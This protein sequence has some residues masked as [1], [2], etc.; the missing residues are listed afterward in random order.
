M[1]QKDHG[2]DSHQYV[3]FVE[4][5]ALLSTHLHQ[6]LERI[7]LLAPLSTPIPL[8][9][10]MRVYDP[11]DGQPQGVRFGWLQLPSDKAQ[12]E[13]GYFFVGEPHRLSEVQKEDLRELEKM[14]LRVMGEQSGKRLVFDLTHLGNLK[15]MP[16]LTADNVWMAWRN[17]DFDFSTWAERFNTCEQPEQPVSAADFVDEQG[18]SYWFHRIAL[19][20]ALGN[21]H[22]ANAE[23]EE[24]A[25]QGKCALA[26][27]QI[28]STQ[29]FDSVRAWLPA[30]KASAKAK[31]RFDAQLR[32]D[33]PF[34]V[35]L[36]S[37]VQVSE[38]GFT[39][40]GLWDPLKFEDS[41]RAGLFEYAQTIPDDVNIMQDDYQARAVG[42]AH[43]QAQL[44]RQMNQMLGWDEEN[45]AS[46]ESGESD[47]PNERDTYGEAAVSTTHTT[48]AASASE[49]LAR[50]RIFTSSLSEEDEP[51]H[52]VSPNYVGGEPTLFNYEDMEDEDTSFPTPQA[53]QADQ[54]GFTGNTNGDAN[55]ASSDNAASN[56][57][58]TDSSTN[59][60]HAN[61]AASSDDA[62]SGNATSDGLNNADGP[63]T[64][65]SADNANSSSNTAS[66]H[67]ADSANEEDPWE[68]ELRR[69][70][71]FATIDFFSEEKDNAV[72]SNNTDLPEDWWDHNA[73]PEEK[74]EQDLSTYSSDDSAYEDADFSARNFYA[75]DDS[76]TPSD[77]DEDDFDDDDDDSFVPRSWVS[78]L[79]SSEDE[80]VTLW[81]RKLQ[82]SVRKT[83]R[84]QEGKH[85]LTERAGILAH[86]SI[87]LGRE[88]VELGQWFR[89]A[90][91]FSISGLRMHLPVEMQTN[92]DYRDA[93]AISL[94]YMAILPLQALRASGADTGVGTI[95][96][97]G[98]GGRYIFA[99]LRTLT[100]VRAMSKVYHQITGL[101]KTGL[102]ITSSEWYFVNLV[103]HC[104]RELDTLFKDGVED[105]VE[106]TWPGNGMFGVKFTEQTYDPTAHQAIAT[107]DAAINE[108]ASTWVMASRA[109][110][111]LL[112]IPSDLR[113]S[114]AEFSSLVETVLNDPSLC[115]YSHALSSIHDA[116]Q[117]VKKEL[118]DQDDSWV[119]GVW[120]AKDGDGKEDTL[121]LPVDHPELLDPNWLHV[122]NYPYIGRRTAQIWEK[123]VPLI[124]TQMAEAVEREQSEWAFRMSLSTLMAEMDAPIDLAPLFHVHV[125]QGRMVIVLHM[126]NPDRWPDFRF[127]V[128][129]EDGT[130][131]MESLSGKERTLAALDYTLKVGGMIAAVAFGITSSLTEVTVNVQGFF[132]MS[133]TF[134]HSPLFSSMLQ[135]N[136]SHPGPMGLQMM[137]IPTEVPDSLVKQVDDQKKWTTDDIISAAEK[138]L[139]NNEE[140]QAAANMSEEELA[141]LM[142]HAGSDSVE[143]SDSADNADSM[144][145]EPHGSNPTGAQSD[146]ATH[147]T[148]EDGKHLRVLSAEEQTGIDL[149][150]LTMVSD[151]LKRDEALEIINTVGLK[152]PRNNL[153]AH[154]LYSMLDNGNLQAI[155]P[156]ERSTSMSFRPS[157]A[158]ELP[159]TSRRELSPQMAK[160]L[161]AQS[162]SDLAIE[163]DKMYE[164][165]A[166]QI[167]TICDQAASRMMSARDASKEV[168]RYLE[169]FPDPELLEQKNDIFQAIFDGKSYKVSDTISHE[170]ATFYQQLSL[171]AANNVINSQDEAVVEYRR[172]FL[173]AV[174]R[175][176]YLWDRNP[177][178]K[179]RYF[180]D[181][182]QRLRYNQVHMVP[183]HEQQEKLN[184]KR[185]AHHLKPLPLTQ[186]IPIPENLFACVDLIFRYADAF[187][188]DG[189]GQLASDWMIEHSPAIPTSHY[190]QGGLMHSHSDDESALH[191]VFNGISASLNA[192]DA[193]AGYDTLSVI[194]CKMTPDIAVAC[195]LRALELSGDLPGSFR[196]HLNTNLQMARDLCQRRGFVEPQED[197]ITDILRNFG[198]PMWPVVED[199]M[200]VS[201]SAYALV[202]AGLFV[203]AQPLVGSAFGSG[204][205]FH[206]DVDQSAV[207]QPGTDSE[208]QMLAKR[209]FLTS[210]GR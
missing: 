94:F 150:D 4:D 174:D 147:D 33:K 189:L 166:Q 71:Q 59:S 7:M 183:L 78:K 156:V 121:P 40:F 132:Q 12:F 34:E 85:F 138:A 64:S 65:N 158:G 45:E 88:N 27:S 154:A 165:I 155:E 177:R 23:P 142:G 195:S 75:M 15:E 60:A 194:L 116:M 26:F 99:D 39:R 167:E 157:G 140:A 128:A 182:A 91:G 50:H 24:D 139:E 159:E 207:D 84:P 192:R 134:I 152:D 143:S 193:A 149:W 187:G 145:D 115:G 97:R 86:G 104:A 42:N 10:T 106:A 130:V 175:A 206:N 17:T 25:Q 146:I 53:D 5:P 22:T 6:G 136:A 208:I 196:E 185:V 203:L 101:R 137:D 81:S 52:L 190:L 102:I 14:Y 20:D 49:P 43:S 209:Y 119:Y 160:T 179:A 76:S 67:T 188:V 79:L 107:I 135:G 153:F 131:E 201:L 83:K 93:L 204:W 127:R 56:S 54:S 28:D 89:T 73:K 205:V 31:A 111:S 151:R 35:D 120:P 170:L 163:R 200:M 141:K 178:V 21:I 105:E 109:L 169:E 62:T 126:V 46:D 96:L 30:E 9:T 3:K 198:I 171:F 61:G 44:I 181:Y 122:A 36:D 87:V 124:T 103:R 202:E 168:Q 164:D 172:N 29:D 113:F 48:S 161:G 51:Y 98:L 63:S 68:A 118:E 18:R 197:E 11:V 74:S 16:A 191:A 186:V 110:P 144:A 100:T 148:T 1:M 199:Q 57:S 55:N 210:L 70:S 90:D 129:D 77:D 108:F 66:S 41:S 123:R 13:L 114:P 58:D 112:N 47:Q 82:P 184:A 117:P 19:G 37:Q 133:R 80:K 69:Q 2:E 125:A 180:V 92:L 162:L 95:G 173:E 38:E 8:T 176:R 32:N 72:R